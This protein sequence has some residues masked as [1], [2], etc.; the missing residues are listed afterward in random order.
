MGLGL[1][2]CKGLV[3]GHGGT[4]GVSSVVGVGSEFSFEIPFKIVG[5]GQSAPEELSCYFSPSG[6]L[7]VGESSPARSRDS[8]LKS[9]VIRT[10]LSSLVSV[11]AFRSRSILIVDDSKFIRILLSKSI[12]QMKYV[13]IYFCLFPC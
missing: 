6:T 12:E 5:S 7:L 13:L 11:A 4:V 1:Y 2:I 9:P 8:L 3:E 10:T